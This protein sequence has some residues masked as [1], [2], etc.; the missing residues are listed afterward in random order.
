MIIKTEGV[1]TEFLESNFKRTEAYGGL[2]W[3]RKKLKVRL[4]P[5]LYIP[6]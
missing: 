3:P 4:K 2:S 5:I 1:N 6:V